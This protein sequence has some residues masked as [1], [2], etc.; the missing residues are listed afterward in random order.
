MLLAHR[1]LE[2][3]L[4]LAAGAGFV[5]FCLCA[6]AGYLVNDA[7]DRQ[8][9]RE[10][11]EKRRRPLAAGTVSASAAHSLA[12]ALLAVAFVLAWLSLPARFLLV[13]AAYVAMTLG[14]SFGLKRLAIVDVLVL[15]GLYTLRILA[16]GA[17]T[18]VV[19]SPWLLAFSMFFFLSLALL[20]R[21]AELRLLET[22]R[23]QPLAGRAYRGED[24][25][26]LRGAGVAAGLVSILV[27]AL[28]ATSPAVLVLYERPSLLW[29]VGALLAY[30]ILRMWMKAHRAEMRHDP[31][32]FAATDRP[33]WVAAALILAALAAAAA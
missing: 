18:G 27:L 13:L 5:A 33:T 8:A 15:A 11:P 30:W 22:E 20:K 14:Y 25:D 29:I 12:G 7:A 21:Y 9:D 32:L 16:G 2:A 19:V 24:L 28:Y 10:H 4:W 6:S 23:G 26:V 31:V 1:L 17:A 3:E